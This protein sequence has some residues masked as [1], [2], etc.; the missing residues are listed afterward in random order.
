MTP[1]NITISLTNNCL[2][3][4]DLQVFVEQY[5]SGVVDVET[6]IFNV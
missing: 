4:L 2:Q 3:P 1:R 5:K 6:G